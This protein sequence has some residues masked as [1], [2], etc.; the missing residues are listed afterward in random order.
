MKRKFTQDFLVDGTPLLMPDADINIICEDLEG[1]TGRDESGFTHR[2][3]LRSEVKTWQFVY[4][5]LTAEEYAYI[6]ELLRGKS[7]F[8]FTFKDEKNQVQTVKAYCK[9]TSASWWSSRMGL[10]KNLQ[11]DVIEC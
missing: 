6:K 7:T 11:F 8:A 2:S 4:A 3:V 1:E 5:I 10:Y 9:Q